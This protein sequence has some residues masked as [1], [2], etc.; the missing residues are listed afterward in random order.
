MQV[1]MHYYGTYAMA[2]A[3]GI[4]DKDA[5]IIAY[6]AQYVDDASDSN[7]ENKNDGG[8]LVG[9]TTAHHLG[10][11]VLRKSPVVQRKVWVPCHFIPGGEGKDMEEKSICLPDSIIARQMMK[12]HIEMALCGKSFGLELLGVAT[13]A[14]M[15]TFSHYGFSGF[16]SPYNGIRVDTLRIWTKNN[17]EYDRLKMKFELLEKKDKNLCTGV[18]R[19]FK[20]I[21]SKGA[22]LL[23]SALG[24]GGALSFP[25]RPYLK[26]NFEYHLP[27]LGSGTK[28]VRENYSDCF[29]ACRNLHSFFCDFSQRRYEHPR[30]RKF[31]EIEEAV[32]DILMIEGDKH[33]RSEGWKKRNLIPES[34]NYSAQDWENQKKQFNQYATSEEGIN[35]EVY[36]FHQAVAYHR[37]YMLKDLLPSHGIAA[38]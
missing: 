38:H 2:L 37:Y 36:R 11:S 25:D 27:R 8:L 9:F 33:T 19:F 12:N 4:P 29:D 26:W 5:E 6:A 18:P 22:Q 28:S 21:L 3:A 1:D 13:H 30:V 34:A 35:T 16:S 7:N 23:S 20:K 31:E 10:R 24:H 14:Y 15:D 32:R 17:S